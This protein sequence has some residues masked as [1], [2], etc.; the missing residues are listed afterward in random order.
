[1]ELGVFEN[2]IEA[3]N[4]KIARS[5]QSDGVYVSHEQGYSY[6]VGMKSL[7]APEVILLGQSKDMAEEIFI[8]LHQAVARGVAALKPGKQLE[9]LLN[10]PGRL[11]SVS[12]FEKMSYFYAARTFFG[13]WDFDSLVLNI[14]SA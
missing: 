1:M 5:I 6:T 2:G 3:H 12:E 7:D 14:E 11:E 13:T 4:N 8:T 10:S 9:G